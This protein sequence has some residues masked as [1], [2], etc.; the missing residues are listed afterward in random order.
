MELAGS[1]PWL[2]RNTT[3]SDGSVQKKYGLTRSDI[4]NGVRTGKLQYQDSA[5]A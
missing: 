3:L 4:I 5:E 1:N 2:G